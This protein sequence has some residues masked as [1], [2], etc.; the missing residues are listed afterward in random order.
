MAGKMLLGCQY[1]L[2]RAEGVLIEIPPLRE[3]TDDVPPLAEH[4]YRRI[5]PPPA[6]GRPSLSDDVI[7]CLQRYDWPGNVSELRS[8]VRGMVGLS[9]GNAVT[10]DMLPRSIIA[11]HPPESD[12]ALIALSGDFRQMQRQLVQ[13]VLLRFDGNKTATANALGLNRRK[14]YRLL[15]D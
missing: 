7:A 11:S 8:V 13:N 15:G 2:H 1:L 3:R 6:Q 14:L 12:K 10:R 4:F 5:A 9:N